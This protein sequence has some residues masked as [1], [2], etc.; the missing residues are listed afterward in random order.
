[1]VERILDS[2]IVK[3]MLYLEEVLH[4]FGIES[5]LLSNFGQCFV[6]AF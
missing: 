5:D 3:S 1:M 2:S 4:L 6:V